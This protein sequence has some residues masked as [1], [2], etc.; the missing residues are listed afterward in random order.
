MSEAPHGGG[1]GAMSQELPS[2]FDLLGIDPHTHLF[3]ATLHDWMPVI[4]SLLVGIFLVTLSIIAT[5]KM[6]KIPT[7]L[8]AFM[9]IVVSGLNNFF[10][11]VIG[12]S[13]VKYLPFLGTL[14]L[15]IIIMNF[16]GLIPSMHSP[17]NSLNTTLALGLSTFVYTQYQG[18]RVLG[19]KKFFRH[20]VGDPLFMSPLMFPLHVLGE[21]VKPISLSLRLFGNLTGEDIA[22]AI[23]V[24]LAPYILGIIPI[25]IH[26]VMIVLAILFSTIQAVVFSLLSAIYIGQSTGALGGG[27]H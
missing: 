4:M 14:F 7:G 10:Q 8:Q 5:R 16:W 27:E 12:H 17:T 23:M 9:E 21:F 26:V 15:Y 20:L 24:G 11:S 6:K 1:G 25:P 13:A 22:I 3:G 18:F 2:I 19:V